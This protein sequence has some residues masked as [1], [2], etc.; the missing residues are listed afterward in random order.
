MMDAAELHRILTCPQTSLRPVVRRTYWRLRAMK[1][2]RSQRFACPGAFASWSPLRDFNQLRRP[3]DLSGPWI[4]ATISL[5]REFEY[6]R[7]HDSSR[8]PPETNRH[9][10]A[11]PSFPG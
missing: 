10:F 6:N 8:E 4:G 1:A 9:S 3:T 7:G 2:P 11:C 5:C